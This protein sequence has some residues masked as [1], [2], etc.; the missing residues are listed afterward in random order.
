LI[1]LDNALKYTPPGGSVWVSIRHEPPYG[2][3]QID[4]SGE[5]IPPEHLE[6]V[7]ERFHRVDRS[8]SRDTGGTGLGLAI[9][10][11]LVM[12][13]AG[14]LRIAHRPGGGTRV[15][16]MIPLAAGAEE[17]VATDMRDHVPVAE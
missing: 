1:V 12:A 7:F 8:R 11:S 14:Q 4:D 10:H 17:L 6:R 9:A 3:L 15:R 2:V 13:H 16:I 5:G